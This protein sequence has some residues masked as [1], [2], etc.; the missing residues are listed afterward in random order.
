MHSRYSKKRRQGSAIIEVAIS[1]GLMIVLAALGSDVTLITYAM[2][3]NDKACRDATRAAAQ[4]TSSASA[5]QAAQTQLSVHATDGSFVSQPVLVSQTSPNFVYNDYG[6]NPPTNQSPYVTVT[7]ST[8]I[9]LPAPIFFLSMH[10]MP[11]GSVQ[12]VRSYTY[13]IIR[14]K[15]YG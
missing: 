10:F 7:T 12:F 8:N 1:I 11:N 6:G 9:K 5:L 13:P 14:E 2:F 3:L 15:F 4:Q